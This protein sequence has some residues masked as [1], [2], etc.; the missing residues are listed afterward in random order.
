MKH[1]L[2]SPGSLMSRLFLS[3]LLLVLTAS[4]AIAER[5]H[6]YVVEVEEEGRWIKLDDGFIW[7]VYPRRELFGYIITDSPA[8]AQTWMPGDEVELDFND[9][10]ENLR[11]IVF[12]LFNLRNSTEIEV[13][14]GEQSKEWVSPYVTAID[15]TGCLLTFSLKYHLA[16]S[17]GTCWDVEC[18]SNISSV[19]KWSIGDRIAVYHSEVYHPKDQFLLLNP[20]YGNKGGWFGAGSYFNYSAAFVMPSREIQ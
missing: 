4:S 18:L 7:N 14:Y 1:E 13:T 2:L 9:V 11:H 17:D 5:S 6:H 12:W 3:F 16:L 19:K 15:S 8:Q 10:G 20:D